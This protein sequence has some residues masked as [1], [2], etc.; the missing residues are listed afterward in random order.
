[1]RPICAPCPYKNWMSIILVL[2]LSYP[3]IY[4]SWIVPMSVVM[5]CANR[6]WVTTMNRLLWIRNKNFSCA[7]ARGHWRNQGGTVIHFIRQTFTL[8]WTPLKDKH[9]NRLNYLA[10]SNQQ[11]QWTFVR[12]KLATITA[13]IE[14]VS[15][16]TIYDCW[17]DHILPCVEE[18][19]VTYVRR[20]ALW[21]V[22][23]LSK[24]FH[25]LI[26][27]VNCNR[28]TKIRKDLR[29]RECH[30]REARTLDQLDKVE[31]R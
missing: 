4:Q 20:R 30:G 14:T 9:C 15:T 26:K 8:F 16:K 3:T 13:P 21:R 10:E 23:N 11:E 5:Y 29:G 1:M 25:V 2:Y 27:H 6:L 17:A 7:F 12:V 18:H 22:D 28:M 31:K 19:C 24:L